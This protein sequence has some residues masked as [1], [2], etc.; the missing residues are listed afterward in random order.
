[1]GRMMVGAVVIGLAVGLVAP[2]TAGAQSAAPGSPTPVDAAVVIGRALDGLR[3]LDAWSF[4]DRATSTVWSGLETVTTGT[5]VNG[6]PWRHAMDIATQGETGWRR[7]VIGKDGWQNLYDGTF[8]PM[9]KLGIPVPGP[10][11]LW[12]FEPLLQRLPVGGQVLTDLGPEL[13]DGVQTEHNQG[14]TPDWVAEAAAASPSPLVSPAPGPSAAPIDPA[15]FRAAV[16]LWVDAGDGHL[17]ASDVDSVAAFTMPGTSVVEEY[18]LREQTRIGD[19][20]DGGGTVTKPSLDV[21]GYGVTD[22]ADPS[23]APMVLAAITNLA[24]LDSYRATVDFLGNSYSGVSELTVDNG[25]P[26]AAQLWSTYRGALVT[27][28]LAIGKKRWAS[29]VDAPRWRPVKKGETPPCPAPCTVASLTA[30]TS[31]IGAVSEAATYALI[32]DD[33]DLDGTPTIHLRST[34]GREMD[35]FGIFPG[36]AD[37]WIAKDGGYLLKDVFDGTAQ[38]RTITISGVNDPANALAAPKR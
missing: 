8:H 15:E 27:G 32:S 19:V 14:Q 25:K 9:K 11:D 23:L 36:T 22:G 12:P 33:E 26:A 10:A 28:V 7:V 2:V 29:A 20:A 31:T 3:S 34:A 17:I 4:E 37:L 21:V 1:M 13:L 30:L 16:D 18:V 38:R 35:S 24:T 6:T 5:V